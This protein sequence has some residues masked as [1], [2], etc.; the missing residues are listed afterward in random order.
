MENM[1]SFILYRVQ[2]DSGT[3]PASYPKRS[4]GYFPGENPVGA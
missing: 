2:T 4:V 3:H 1:L